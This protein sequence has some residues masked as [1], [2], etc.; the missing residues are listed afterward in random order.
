MCTPC[1]RR[2]AGQSQNLEQIPVDW[3]MLG[4]IAT[5]LGL[6]LWTGLLVYTSAFFFSL[7]QDLLNG[8]HLVLGGLMLGGWWGAWRGRKTWVGW[9]LGLQMLLTVGL[10][11]LYLSR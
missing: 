4:K 7:G 6:L 1:G 8:F 5:S 3:V 10:Y 2:D 9:A 11:I